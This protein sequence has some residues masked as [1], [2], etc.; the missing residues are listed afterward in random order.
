MQER[1]PR[2]RNYFIDEDSDDAG[3]PWDDFLR[4]VHVWSWMRAGGQ[5]TVRQ[6]ANEFQVTDDVIRMVVS[7]HPWMFLEGGDDPEH[8]V[9][10]HDGD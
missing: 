4:A 2:D 6:A 8:Q 9:I 3:V 1:I 10:G 5:V 7:Q